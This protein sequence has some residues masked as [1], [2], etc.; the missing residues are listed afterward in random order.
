[1]DIKNLAQT[2]AGSFLDCMPDPAWVKDA[3]HRYVAVNAAFRKMCEFQV[4]GAE[5]E[6]I[7]VTDFNLFPLEMAEQVQEKAAAMAEERLLDLLLPPPR[8]S[9]GIETPSIEQE[10]QHT[11]TREKLRQQFREGKLDDRM[12]ELEQK[13]KVMPFGIISN[14]GMEEIEMNLK[15]MLGGLLPEKTKRRKVKVLSLIHI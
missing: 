13:E 1:M 14:I 2:L 4:D 6:V 9:P 7:D 15:E 11:G 12:V 10:E 3:G 8:T 5:V